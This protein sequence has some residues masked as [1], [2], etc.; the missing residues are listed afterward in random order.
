M[1]DLYW[2]KVDIEAEGSPIELL[3]EDYFDSWIDLFEKLFSIIQK[4]MLLKNLNYY[5]IVGI[6]MRL[7][8]R[9]WNY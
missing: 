6:N 4:E 2:I 9:N 3:I 7:Q 8:E 1:R 5:T